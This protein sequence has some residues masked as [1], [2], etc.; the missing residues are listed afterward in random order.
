MGNPPDV[1]TPTFGEGD[2][3]LG[4]GDADVTLAYKTADQNFTTAAFEND[5]HLSF[6]LVG[7]AEYVF[8]FVL[9][10]STSVSGEAYDVTLSGPAGPG[11]LIYSIALNTSATARQTGVKTVYDSGLGLTAGFG[12]T[13][14]FG[15]MFGY[16]AVPPGG[17]TLRVKHKCETGGGESATVYAGS[18]GYLRRV[19]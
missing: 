3:P 13:P 11:A 19:A 12:T 6:V 18:H 14:F 15:E 7:G 5:N 9:F 1:R 10:Y 2:G 16:V 8:R 17:G 4:T